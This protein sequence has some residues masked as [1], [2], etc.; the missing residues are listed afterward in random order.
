M[1]GWSEAEGRFVKVKRASPRL[2]ELPSQ[3]VTETVPPETAPAA[4]E[5]E[6]TTPP[7]ALSMPEVS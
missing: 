1:L 5:Q 2:P 3:P 4:V 7:E 6:F